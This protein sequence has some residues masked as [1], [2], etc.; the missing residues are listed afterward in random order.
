MIS[1]LLSKDMGDLKV[2]IENCEVMTIKSI[3]CGCNKL[4]RL[5]ISIMKMVVL[6]QLNFIT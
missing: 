3:I 1:Y 5:D 6:G 4:I 2:K